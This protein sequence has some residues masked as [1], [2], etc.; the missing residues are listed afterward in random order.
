MK[1]KIE[2]MYDR[3]G[4]VEVR[5]WI[6]RDACAISR[7]A[8]GDATVETFGSRPISIGVMSQAIATSLAIQS[9]AWSTI[10]IS[11]CGITLVPGGRTWILNAQDRS[12]AV[13]FSAS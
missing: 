4:L 6:E 3:I 12:P 5:S 8:N 11:F 7:A 10:S 13:A 9:S 2:V 1:S